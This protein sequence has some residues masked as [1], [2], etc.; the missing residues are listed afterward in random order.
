MPSVQTSRK[1]TMLVHGDSGSGKS[2]LFN[3]APGPRLLLDAE[4]R[5]D[6]LADLRKDPTGMTPQE[7][8]RWDP[9]TALPD[10]SQNPDVVTVVDVHDWTDIELAYRVLRAGEHGFRSVGLDSLPEAQQRLI[11]DIAGVEQMTTQN[12]GEALRRLDALV[13]DLRDLRKHKT[14]PLDAVV[15]VAGSA[16]KDDKMR[17][18][19]Q[20]QM[21][22]RAPYHFDVVGYLQKG[23]NSEQQKVRYMTIDGYVSGILAKDNTHVL[24]AHYGEHVVFP[25]VEQMLNILNN[26]GDT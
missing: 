14:N 5:A 24:S 9:R 17:P 18:M 2:W 25:D 21:A 12:W 7:L 13:R 8:L 23:I 4:G 20:G 26:T 15:V 19:L 1:L 11:G 16:E 22:L 10:E 6:Y 3:T